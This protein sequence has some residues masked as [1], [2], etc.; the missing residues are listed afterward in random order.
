MVQTL[1]PFYIEAHTL[2]TTGS[3]FCVFKC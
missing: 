2:V 3:P 1:Y